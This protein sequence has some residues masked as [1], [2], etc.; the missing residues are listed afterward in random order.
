MIQKKNKA[1][2][3]TFVFKRHPH[4]EL[5]NATVALRRHTRLLISKWRSWHIRPMTD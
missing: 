3:T 1:A 5:S 4:P 2:N